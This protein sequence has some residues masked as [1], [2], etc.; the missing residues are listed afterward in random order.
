MW[1][2]R[3]AS[4]SLRLRGFSAGT[5]RACCVKLTTSKV[6]AK[7]GIV[8]SPQISCKGSLSF[9]KFHSAGQTSF[10]II[11][12]EISSQADAR[13]KKE[14]DDM[15]YE[16]ETPEGEVH[17][18]GGEDFELISKQDSS[19]ENEGVE[20]LNNGQELSDTEIDSTEKESQQ[21]GIR[22]ELFKEITRIPGLS[23]NS[24]LTKWVEEGKELSRSEISL[25]IHNL[26]VLRMYGKAL[27]LSDWVE[28]KQ[29]IDLTEKDYASQLDLIAK[30][31]GLYK[32][33]TYVESIPKSFR[34]EHV[35]RTLLANCVNQ[36][37]LK[38]AEEVFTKIKDLKLP[39]SVF[40]CNQML[41]LYKRTDKR[42]IASVLSLMEEENIK[43]SVS[44]HK[45][46]IDL[47][48]KYKDIAGM[49]QI[50]EKM[51]AEGVELDIQIQLALAKQYAS[52]G[53]KEKVEAVLKEIE[54]GN[55]EENRS[56]CRYLFT[57]YADLGKAD[58]VE[59][60]WAVCKSDPR[61]YE[62]L[63]AIEAWGKLKKIEEAEA[64]F[65]MMIKKWKRLTCR[66]YAV[67]LRAYTINNMLTK[68]K[69]LINR[70]AN[71]GHR[72]GPVTWDALV[73][74]FVEAGEVEK[75]DSL[76]QKAIR[77]AHMRPL[78]DTYIV[79][80]EQYAERG[81]VHNAEKNFYRMRQ[82]GYTSRLSG[83]RFL[84]QGYIN[85]KLP[86]YGMRE[87]LK[88]DNLSPYKAFMVQLAEVDAFRRTPVSNLLD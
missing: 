11:V 64:I 2:L 15:E 58:E 52:A 6:E 10:N 47:K 14:D 8:E 54:G 86:A 20:D 29:K 68:G 67:L 24:V 82:V 27:Q 80:L 66:Q 40:T 85:A 31:H 77:Q 1:A 76:L 60:I 21:K 22:S 87:R 51:K 75:A 88:A 18:N 30:V 46:L 28:A 56:A 61:T 16:L 39:V 73:R 53:L 78:Y 71:S 19:Y 17:D 5:S 69:D 36:N 62:C 44:S 41:L 79:I 13:S 42:K 48:G 57:I 23:V 49:E 7:P 33:E 4:I 43:P 84:I 34:G 9:Q 55:L 38:K 59:R 45:I 12:R 70:M 50:V 65:E 83:F 37:N 63:A 3:R 74:L 26:R 35:Y 25:A 72:L 81:D 32:A